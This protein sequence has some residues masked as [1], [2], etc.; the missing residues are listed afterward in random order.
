MPPPIAAGAAVAAGVTGGGGAFGGAAVVARPTGAPVVSSRITDPSETLSPTLTLRSCTTPPSGAGTSIVALSDSSMISGSSG[1]TVSPGFT[2][3]SITGTSLKSPISGTRTSATPAG[4]LAGA[5]GAEML[6]FGGA[7]AGA[8]VPASSSRI[9]LPSLTLSPTAD[10]H[11][12][13]GAGG[14]RRNVQR[15]LVGLQCKQHVFRL[16]RIARLDHDLDD[17]D[18]CEIT[19]VGDFY[20]DCHWTTPVSELVVQS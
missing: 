18:V 7:G 10:I 6:V 3:I 2:M 17:R 9:T 19:D 16:H 15:R 5:G 8:A 12:C 20:F 11:R 14:R 1:F 13:H 4:A